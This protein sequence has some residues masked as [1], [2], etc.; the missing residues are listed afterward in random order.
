MRRGLVRD[1]LARGIADDSLA[2]LGRFCTKSLDRLLLARLEA[3][4]WPETDTAIP[5]QSPGL[6]EMVT[7]SKRTVNREI[8]CNCA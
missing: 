6:T 3:D 8:L 5:L 7:V 4:L 1:A 2:S